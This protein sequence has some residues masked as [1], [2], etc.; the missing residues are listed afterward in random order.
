MGRAVVSHQLPFHAHTLHHLGI[1]Q[2]LHFA[3]LN[4]F[5]QTT[6][7]IRNDLRRPAP[8]ANA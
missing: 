6:M 5:A 3:Q 4:P 8:R 2:W 1:L 7:G